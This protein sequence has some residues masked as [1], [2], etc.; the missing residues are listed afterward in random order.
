LI[1]TATLFRRRF[2]EWIR[3]PVEA[4]V[5]VVAYYGIFLVLFLGAKTFGGPNVATGDTL[6]AIAIGYIV[7][8]LAQQSYQ[9]F[10]GQ[11]LQE[12]MAGTLEQL[13]LSPY[14]LYSV[15]M[16]DFI[17]Q[18][19]LMTAIF[20]VVI[21][22]IM[23]TTGRWLHFDVLSVV[24]LV[25][26]TMAGVVGFGLVMGGLGLVFK[27]VGTLG[28]ILSLGFLPLVA[29]PID[30]YPLLKLLP[31]GHGNVLLRDVL[32]ESRSVF[33]QPLELLILV[34]VSAVYVVLGSLVFLAMDRRAR[35]RALLGQY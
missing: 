21:V 20:G 9:Q 18:A 14:G 22:P 8:L 15:L 5:G 3:Y 32:V 17:A 2:L 1:L 25:V 30:R 12:S 4:V 16:V 24:P 13:A 23:A 10:Q 35:D 19:L 33:D 11:V 7:F 27:R 34:G 29:A 6:S 26:L 28:G 31:V